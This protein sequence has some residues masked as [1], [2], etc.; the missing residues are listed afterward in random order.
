[1][2]VLSLTTYPYVYLLARSAFLT[3]GRRALEA[4]QSLGYGRGAATWRVA[5]PMARPWIIAGVALTAMETLADFGAVYIFNA[6]TFTTAIY[7]AWF[8]MRSVNTALQL[9]GVLMVFVLIVFVIERHSRSKVS[10]ASTRDMSREAPRLQLSPALRRLACA[11]ACVVFTVAFVLPVIQLAIWA[12][13][14]IADLDARYFG[15]VGRSLLLGGSA[16]IVIVGVSVVLAYILRR[17]PSMF[18]GAVIRLATIGY[19]VP[20]T[21]LAVG[22]L[23][24]IILLNNALQELLRSRFGESAP[25]LLF[26]GTLLAVLFGYLARFLAVGFNPIESGLQRITKNID[27]AAIGLGVAGTQLLRRVHVPL[28]RTSLATA[29]TLVFVDV[30][31]EMPI[32]LIVRPFGW[33]TLAIRVF[34]MTSEG[35]WERAA[36]PSIAIVLAGLVP[37]ALLTRRGAHVA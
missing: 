34:E 35:E 23:V 9:A 36:L 4:A 33:D 31:K 11:F 6:R 22:V 29:A 8:G 12:V 30:M 18:S 26:Q 14:R 17:L 27:E 3:Q 16:A 20:G 13:E 25:A 28:L 10:F 24:P 1:M 7:G 5:L 37:V 15:F 21:V 2:L 19:A 32:T